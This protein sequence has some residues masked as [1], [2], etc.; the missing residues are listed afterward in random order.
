MLSTEEMSWQPQLTQLIASAGITII[1]ADRVRIR[2]S[3]PKRYSVQ[4][5]KQ[6]IENLSLYYQCPNDLPGLISH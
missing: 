2:I 6:A 5:A 4:R 3:M 1:K